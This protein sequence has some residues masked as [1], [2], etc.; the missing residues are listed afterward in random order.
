MIFTSNALAARTI[1]VTGASSGLGRATALMIAECGGRVVATG[2]DEARLSET[3]AAL[4][5]TG[6]RAIAADLATAENAASIVVQAAEA[7]GG[8]DGLFHAAGTELVRPA[9]LVKQKHI[10]AVFGAA[11][12]GAIGIGSAAGKSNI[13]RP[14]SSI[15]LMSSAAAH[16]GR[17]G[18]STYS[19]AKAGIEALTRSLAWELRGIRVNAIAAGGV[20]TEMHERLL[21]GLSENS[22]SEY[23]QAH[24]LGFGRPEDVASAAVFL[25]S[26]AATWVTGAVW[27]VDG[28]YTA[29]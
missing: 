1:L 10:D 26:P 22:L 11:L 29:G 21:R 25:L 3:L 6:H 16:R 9:R 28:G 19:S 2:R 18:L 12:F 5:G 15:V 17:P 13:F 27:A 24:A 14:G 23:E 8:L 20:Q 7:E 4:P